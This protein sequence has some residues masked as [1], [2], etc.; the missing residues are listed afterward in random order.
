MIIQAFRL[1]PHGQTELTAASLLKDV[2]C[3]DADQLI[4]CVAAEPVGPV[5]K[6]LQS[7]ALRD[8]GCSLYSEFISRI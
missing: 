8:Q 7:N 6:S 5:P 2:H 1:E 4:A 3:S